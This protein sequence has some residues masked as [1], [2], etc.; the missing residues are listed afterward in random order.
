M[1]IQSVGNIDY[2]RAD[3]PLVTTETNSGNLDYWLKRPFRALIIVMPVE[4]QRAGGK[5]V[6]Y[7]D[8][9]KFFLARP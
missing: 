4:V 1:P 2:W 5:V 8:F 3:R 9:P 6:G 7:S